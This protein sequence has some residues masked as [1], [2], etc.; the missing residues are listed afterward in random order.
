[1]RPRCDATYLPL[2]CEYHQLGEPEAHP[3]HLRVMIVGMRKSVF[4]VVCVSVAALALTGCA[5]GAQQSADTGQ[6]IA[7]GT[8]TQNPTD[9]LENSKSLERGQALVSA[10]KQYK[11]TYRWNRSIFL[12]GPNREVIWKSGPVRDATSVIMRAD[13]NLIIRNDSG[14]EWSS[15]TKAFA[16]EAAGPLQAFVTNDG[17]FQIRGSKD[18][19]LVWENGVRLDGDTLENGKSLERGQAL[20]SANKQYKATLQSN[21]RLVLTGPDGRIWNSVR[22]RGSTIV[23]MRDDNLIIHSGSGPE[24][25]SGTKAF[26][27][28]ATGPLQALVTNDGKFQIRGSKNWTVV[29]ENGKPV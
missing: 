11:A 19:R 17:K 25:S 14:A 1:M 6:R 15:G 12:T 22:V 5:G 2:I 27:T 13:N 3:S 7:G 28:E 20:V 8:Q 9:T 4:G 16:T 18:Q 26:A 23:I 10:N 29:W 24:W 21:G